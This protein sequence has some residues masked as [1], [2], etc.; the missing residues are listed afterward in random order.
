MSTQ[1]LR[2]PYHWNLRQRLEHCSALDPGTGCILWSGRSTV[3]GYGILNWQ[4]RPW[5]AHRLAWAEVH[6][7][8]P[9]GMSVLH[10]CDVRSCV[11]PDHLF[12]GTH[13]DNMRDLREKQRQ[14]ARLDHA[15]LEAIRS[16]TGSVHEIAAR[17]GVSFGLVCKIKH[18]HQQPDRRSKTDKL[19]ATMEQLQSTLQD[20]LRAISLTSSPRR[21]GVE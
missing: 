1:K 4:G 18:E 13:A 8:I 19:L 16:A 15:A 3:N 2:C 21:A 10:R 12:L 6:G 5:L 17:H 9:S 11:N 14:R 7:P 20:V